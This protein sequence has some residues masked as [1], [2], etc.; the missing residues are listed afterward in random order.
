MILFILSIFSIF[1]ICWTRETS[2]FWG[3][4]LSLASAGELFEALD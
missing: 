2:K 4:N 3:Y 1:F